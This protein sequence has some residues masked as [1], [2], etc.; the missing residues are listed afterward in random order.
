MAELKI[1]GFAAIIIALFFGITYLLYRYQDSQKT[2]DSTFIMPL[3]RIEGEK[4]KIPGNF[5]AD[6]LIQKEPYATVA[7]SNIYAAQKGFDSI[8]NSNGNSRGL[9]TVDGKLFPK[10]IETAKNHPRKRK[11]IDITED[12]TKNSLQTLL[13]TWTDGSYSPVHKHYE[14]AEVIVNISKEQL[15]TTSSPRFIDYILLLYSYRLLSLWK[16]HWHFSPLTTKALFVVI[17]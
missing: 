7:P 5:G 10:L 6:P 3:N 1:R 14:Y 2:E 9:K 13:N 8:E 12:P 16:E 15:S 4:N 11:M 17:Y